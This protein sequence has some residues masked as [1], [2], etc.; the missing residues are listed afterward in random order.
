MKKGSKTVKDEGSAKNF[1]TLEERWT[2]DGDMSGAFTMYNHEPTL[3]ELGLR[4]RRL[5]A[6]TFY[7]Q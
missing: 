7:M 3:A 4:G 5:P 1:K 2:L 6:C